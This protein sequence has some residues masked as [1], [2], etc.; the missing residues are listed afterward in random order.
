M[1]KIMAIMSEGLPQKLKRIKINREERGFQAFLTQPP[2]VIVCH[3]VI[4]H[5]TFI[6]LR[7]RLC[8]PNKSLG[9]PGFGSS[10]RFIFTVNG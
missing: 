1:Q 5:L 6:Y 7:L 3:V 4:N 2:L 10:A 9:A 8:N